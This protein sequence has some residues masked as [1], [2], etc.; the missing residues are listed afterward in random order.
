MRYSKTGKPRRITDAQVRRIRE[1]KPFNQILREIGIA[2][3]H[4]RAIRNGEYSHKQKS[5]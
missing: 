3:S 2:G 4:A 1:W 5:P